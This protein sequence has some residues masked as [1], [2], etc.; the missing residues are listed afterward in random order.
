MNRI[1]SISLILLIFLISSCQVVGDIFKAGVWV[2][3]LLVIG[4]IALVIY[5]V[6]RGINKN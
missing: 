1:V 3:V 2:G 5:L 4:F 6:T